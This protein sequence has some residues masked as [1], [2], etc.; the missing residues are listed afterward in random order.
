MP[1][2]PNLKAH[3]KESSSSVHNNNNN[4]NNNN[5]INNT[6]SKQKHTSKTTD[7]A[8]KEISEELRKNVDYFVNNIGEISAKYR[9]LLSQCVPP[10]D[11]GTVRVVPAPLSDNNNNNINLI[12]NN[13]NNNNNI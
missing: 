12:S 6:L 4:N 3:R 13:N 5:K 2:S 8:I 1:P 11:I 7:P 10:E 9:E